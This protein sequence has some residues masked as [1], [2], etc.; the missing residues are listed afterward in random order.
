MSPVELYDAASGGCA[1]LGTLT[2]EGDQPIDVAAD[3]FAD[4]LDLFDFSDFSDE[5]LSSITLSNPLTRNEAVKLLGEIHQALEAVEDRLLRLRWCLGF[6]LV[7]TERPRGSGR[8]IIELLVQDLWDQFQIRTSRTLLYEC[9]KL[10]K[11][12]AGDFRAYIGWIDEQKKL[13]HRPVR[14]SDVQRLCLGGRNNPDV[15]G[16]EA[17]DEGDYRDA[18]RGIEAIERIL[19]R[20]QEGNDEAQGVIEGIR[21]SVAGLLLL[22]NGTPETPRSEEYLAFVRRHPCLVCKRPADSHHA[23]GRKGAGMKSSDYTTVPLCRV[24]HIEL[25]LTHRVAFEAEYDVDLFEVAYNLLHRYLTGAW[26]TM[27][28]SEKPADA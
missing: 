15:I 22:S 3:D 19:L 1:I 7:H 8:E 9:A 11:V 4:F 17:A 21:Q 18:E 26:V 20:A 13:R 25:H 5:G 2:S 6:V 10:Y 16:R 27:V 14:W 12:F 24:H 28:L 23:F